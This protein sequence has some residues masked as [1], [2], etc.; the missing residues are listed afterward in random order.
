MHKVIS[1]F[2]QYHTNEFDSKNSSRKL[3]PY[4]T[5]GLREIQ[6][7]VDNPKVVVKQRNQ[8]II[9]SSFPSR[10]FEEQAKNGSYLFLWADLDEHPKP[11]G[12]VRD[13]VEQIVGCDFEIYTTSSATKDKPKARILIPLAN[14]LSSQEWVLSQAAL[15][16]LLCQYEI[17]PDRANERYA[18]LCYLPNRGAYYES[19]FERNGIYFNPVVAWG[20]HINLYTESTEITDDY[21]GVQKNTEI[22]EV[23][24]AVSDI[25]YTNLPSDCCPKEEGQRNRCLFTF[26]RYL[27]HLYTHADFEFLRPLV[28]GWHKQFID[29]IGSKNFSETWTDFRRGWSKIKVPYGQGI[30]SIIDSIDLDIPIP[31]TFID[32][33]YGAKEFKLL[34]ICRQLQFVNGDAPFFLAARTAERLIDY[35]FTGAAK[36]LDALV[37]DGFLELITKGKMGR[38]S[39][40]RCIWNE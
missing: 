24:D 15:N 20:E 2:G 25:D 23:I 9:P 35:H 36:M 29:V 7:I 32:L 1:G 26:G 3:I 6:L 31:Q 27:K 17:N 11:I 10:I 5:I 21:R 18:Q 38:A 4:K 16:K 30:E 37:A 34:L 39:R 12:Y 22:T 14:A 33:G 13:V 28:F 40:Y 8:W 19:D